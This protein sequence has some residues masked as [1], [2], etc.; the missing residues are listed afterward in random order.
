MRSP[1]AIVRRLVVA[2]A[3]IAALLAP[4]A[5]TLWVWTPDASDVQER[6][7]ALTDSYG[8]PLMAENDV[9]PLL[10]D[11]VV[12]VEDEH[13]YSHPGIDSIG[14]GRGLLSDVVKVC[15]C[16]GGAPITGALAQDGY[17]GGS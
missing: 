6:V 3:V 1:P 15:P 17:P 9:P 11:A 14:L 8:V 13:F 4:S 7:R 2:A 10:A 16:P 5:A 12:A